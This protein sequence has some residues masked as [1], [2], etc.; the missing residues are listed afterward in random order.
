MPDMNA[1]KTD[2]RKFV[3]KSFDYAYDDR[4]N[5]LLL[6]M[7]EENSANVDYELTG[8]GGY[9]ELKLYDGTNL[10]R[11]DMHRGFK[12][13]I[14]PQ[15][16]SLTVP[17][18]YKQAKIDKM[19]ECKKV[20][21]RLGDSAGLSVYMRALRMFSNAFNPDFLGGDGKPWAATDHP[22][23]S[24]GSS[25]RRYVADPDAG[26]Y[27]NLIAKTLSVTNI[28]EAQ[29]LGGK[30]LTPDG[31]PFLSNYDTLLVSPDLEMEAKKICGDG[32]KLRPV[33]NPEDD[34]NAANPLYDLNYMVVGNGAAGLRGKQWAICDRRQ[35]QEMVKLIYITRPQVMEHEDQNPL[36][37]NFTGYVDYDCGWG[38]ARQIIFSN[39]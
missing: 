36:I 39:P 18:G 26:T 38:D 37:Q 21:K 33:Q 20:G 27:S 13:I 4:K 9:G 10:N 31:L 7:G 8:A 34:T 32:A 11:G 14:T 2:L 24:K 17:I 15:E 16:F 6:I 5:K 1:W 12:T 25:G 30:F 28:C 23:A 19:G 35:M 3:G 22:C 29:T